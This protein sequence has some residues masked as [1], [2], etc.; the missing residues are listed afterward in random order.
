MTKCND[1]FRQFTGTEGYHRYNFGLL[2]TDGTAEIAE[3][4]SSYWFLDI[5]ASYIF[6][7]KVNKEPFQVW[8]LKRIAENK[9]LVTCDDGNDN[10]IIT[11]EISF[12]NFRY[13]EYVVWKMDNVIL[14][15]SEN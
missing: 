6:T 12:S 3:T 8:T 14:L 9:F 2:L 5:I 1:D 10:I 13:D 15:P 4:T 7:P 11:Q